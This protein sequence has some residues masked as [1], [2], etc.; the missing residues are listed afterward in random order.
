MKTPLFICASLF[1]FL[2]PVV[3]EAKD[4]PEFAGSHSKNMM[5]E[6]QH[7]PDSFEPGEK[8]SAKGEIIVSTAKNVQWGVRIGAVTYSAPT[9]VGGKIFIGTGETG[10]GVLK[11]LD[12]ATGKLLWQYSEPYR[13]FPSEVDPGWKFMLGRITPNLGIC[14]T[15]TVEGD[16]VYVVNHRCQVIC[17]DAN[18][19]TNAPP[20]ASANAADTNAAP[21]VRGARVIWTFDMWD[22]GIR[23]ADACNGSP[24]IDGDLLYVNTSNGTDRD[25]QIAYADN[26]KTPAPTAANLIVLEK[27]TGRLV[28]RDDADCIGTNIMHGEWSTPSMGVVNGRKLIF[29]GGG[30]GVCY[31]FEA[32]SSVPEQPVRLKTVWWFDCNPPE[33]KSFGGLD[34]ASHYSLGD[35]RLKQSLNKQ[36]LSSFV[37]TSEIIASPVLYRDRIYVPIGRDPEHGRGRGALW[38]IDATKTG[39]LTS[40]G[41]IWSYQGLDRTLSTPAIVDGLL[42]IGDVAGR[43]HCLDAETGK[44]QWVHETGETL[45]ASTFVADGKIYLPTLR[46]LWILKAGKEFN[47]LARINLGAA[48]WASPVAVDNTLYISSKN[49]LW[50]VRETKP[51]SK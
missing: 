18:G 48:I 47:Q 36:S 43:V 26:R 44:V 2:L 46:S 13:K 20:V 32:L 49:Y 1:A 31:A 10:K 6:G 37:G 23:P 22:Y 19:D 24:L 21:N 4:W 17:L 28:A 38:C 7:L 29:Y 3:T 41:R 15:P 51:G 34:W 45:W 40:T 11:C 42:Y 14:A 5:A 9:V 25:A 27:K 33:Y 39:D 8:D 12:A 35:K 50:A 16:R 30:D